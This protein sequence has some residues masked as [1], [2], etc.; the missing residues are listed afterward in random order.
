MIILF[1][2]CVICILKTFSADRHDTIQQNCVMFSVQSPT[3]DKISAGAQLATP[4][5]ITTVP[6]GNTV[7][8]YRGGGLCTRVNSCVAASFL[9]FLDSTSF[10]LVLN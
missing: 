3:V 9:S 8:Y 5:Y 1:L 6:A 2:N 7:G 10:E 4:Y